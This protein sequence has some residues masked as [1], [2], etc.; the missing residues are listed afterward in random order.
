[1]SNLEK[2]L[3]DLHEGVAR[4]LLSRVQSGQASAA[5]LTAA[6]KFLKDNGVDAVITP[7]S[8]LENLAKS[9][10]FEYPSAPIRSVG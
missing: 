1:M 7:D 4:E 2:I 8:P 3:N 10:P 5:E 9:L 6:I